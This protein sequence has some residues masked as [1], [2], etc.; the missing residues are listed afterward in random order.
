MEVSISNQMIA[1][2]QARARYTQAVNTRQ[3]QEELLKAEQ[4]K[5]SFGTSNISSVI[6][7]QRGLV[8]AQSSEIA[9]SAAYAHAHVS[10]DQVLGQTLEINHVDIN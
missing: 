4:T 5:F 2:R 7:V 8:S 10:L 6:I 1:L 3:L 9:A